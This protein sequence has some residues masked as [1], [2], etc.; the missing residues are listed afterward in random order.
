MAVAGSGASSGSLNKTMGAAAKV[1]HQGF[2][3]KKGGVSWKKRWFTVEDHI[4]TYY[5]RQG[6]PK[7]RGRMVLNAESRVTALPTRPHAFQVITNS[8]ALMVF[9]DTAEEKDTWYALLCAQIEA[10]QER[11]AQRRIRRDTR[12]E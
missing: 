1:Q 8:K 2:L 7:P 6:D 12:C 5:S 9:A 4:V 3:T 10:L 11:A